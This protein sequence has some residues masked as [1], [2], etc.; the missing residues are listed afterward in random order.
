MYELHIVATWLHIISAIYWIGAISFILTALGPVLRQQPSIVVP[1]IMTGVHSRVRR[2]VLIAIV[3]FVVTG[4]FNMYYRG[5]FDAATLFGSSYGN[6]FLLKMIPVAIMFT[7]Y[8]SAPYLMKRFSS[9][10]DDEC[11][12]ESACCEME[13]GHKQENRIFAVLHVV[14]LISGLLAVFLGVRLRG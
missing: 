11:K 6:I 7:L 1:P 13:K 9:Q 12:G 14:A 10:K 4:V 5:L 8:F 2:N 3:I